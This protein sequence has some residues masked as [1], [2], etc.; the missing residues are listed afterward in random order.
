MHG[1]WSSWGKFTACDKPCN[2]GYKYRKRKCNYPVPDFGGN[3][4]QGSFQEKQKCPI[5][6]CRCML[7][8]LSIT[9]IKNYKMQLF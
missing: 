8:N 5:T 1:G 7:L 2:G 4:C 6:K 3:Y 9:C